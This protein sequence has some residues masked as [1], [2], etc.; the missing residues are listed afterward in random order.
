MPKSPD[1]LRSPPGLRFSRFDA[2][3]LVVATVASIATWN[4]PGGVGLLVAIVV[5]HFFLFCN[6]VRLWRVY[7]LVWAGVFVVV[8]VGVTIAVGEPAWGL[9]LALVTPVTLG[10]IVAQIRS[11]H[12]RG[13]GWF[14]VQ[15]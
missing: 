15:Q 9:M 11:G 4:L 13:L 6:V 2:V 10:L 8:A 7:E 3:L 1:M 14:V 5:G 12:Y